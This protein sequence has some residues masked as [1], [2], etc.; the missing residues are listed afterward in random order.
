MNVRC[1]YTNCPNRATDI[2]IT[3]GTPYVLC[4]EHAALIPDDSLFDE[5]Q[6]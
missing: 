3:W 6:P 5:V 2:V 1:A 4:D